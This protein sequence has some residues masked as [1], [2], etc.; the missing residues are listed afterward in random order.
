MLG[1]ATGV[2]SDNYNDLLMTLIVLVFQKNSLILVFN[3]FI[4]LFLCA[5]LV[6]FLFYRPKRIFVGKRLIVFR[7]LV[8]IPIL[9]ELAC[10]VIKYLVGRHVID[11][12]IGVYPLMTTKPPMTFVLFVT[13]ALFVKRQENTFLKAGKTDA[14][15]RAFLKTNYNSLRFSKTMCKTI[16]IVALID[17]V[18]S[19]TLSSILASSTGMEYL[20]ASSTI[21]DCGFGQSTIMLLA[22]PYI[23]LFSYTRTHKNPMVEIVIPI[24]AILILVL[25]YLETAFQLADQLPDLVSGILP[26]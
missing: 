26:H 11:L 6:F 15:Y 16:L 24:A 22:I 8:L 9:Y 18:L 14:D 3:I 21:A 20:A 2:D 23:L 5:L 7:W 12:P 1:K 13:M 4:D 17:A 10:I 25:L 19:I